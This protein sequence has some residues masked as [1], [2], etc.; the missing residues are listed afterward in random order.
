[1]S[2]VRDRL[3]RMP[4]ARNPEREERRVVR[5]V[6]RRDWA[7]LPLRVPLP[8][9]AGPA[10]SGPDRVR[11]PRCRPC[12]VDCARR[13]GRVAHLQGMRQRDR[14]SRPASHRH[15]C[16]RCA[17]TAGRGRTNRPPTGRPAG[18]LADLHV[19]RTGAD[20]VVRRDTHRPRRRCDDARRS[21]LETSGGH[22]DRNTV[23]WRVR[24]LLGRHP[25]Q[26]A[27]ADPG[28]D[29]RVHRCAVPRRRQIAWLTQRDLADGAS[30]VTAWRPAFG[31]HKCWSF[32]VV[33]GIGSRLKTGA[34]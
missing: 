10:A 13:S 29:Q 11:Q 27:A 23:V 15:R 25:P 16:G 31:R 8:A 7:A 30:T 12:R 18:G 6:V 9:R 26:P 32:T 21:L 3:G 4:S 28:G 33:Q 34:T 22:S 14:H 19:R 20:L 5:T 1:M 17:R 2:Q 24:S